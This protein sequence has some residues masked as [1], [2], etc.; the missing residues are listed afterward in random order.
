MPLARLTNRFK[1][2]LWEGRPQLGLWS[3]LCCPQV[4]EVLAQSKFDWILF[5][6]EHSPIEIA[7]LLPLLQAASG[8]NACSAV[9]PPWND[10]V[11]IKRVLDIGAQTVLL[12]FVQNAE[13]ARRAVASVRYPPDG[14]RGVSAG[15]R[16]GRYG[17][18]PA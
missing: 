12:P 2:A 3:T 18:D 17:R 8:G 7:G 10:P 6:A 16:A 4:A 14:I 11:L 13:E 9:R 5:D 1:A 15:T